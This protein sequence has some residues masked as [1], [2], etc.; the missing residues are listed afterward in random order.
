MTTKIASTIFSGLLIGPSFASAAR[1]AAGASGVAVISG[2][3]N[4]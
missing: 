1:A 2:S 4:L 3:I